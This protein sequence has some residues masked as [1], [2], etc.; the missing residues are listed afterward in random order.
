MELSSQSADFSRSSRGY[1]GVLHNHKPLKVGAAVEK[2]KGRHERLSQKVWVPE[3]QR[4]VTWLVLK[5]EEDH[6]LRNAGG[7]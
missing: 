4:A 1:P 6:E 7:P 5:M 3:A 2:R